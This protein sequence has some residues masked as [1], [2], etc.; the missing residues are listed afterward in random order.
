[1]TGPPEGEILIPRCATSSSPWTLAARVVV[2]PGRPGITARK[3]VNRRTLAGMSEG[4]TVTTYGKRWAD[5]Y[6]DWTAGWGW[7][8]TQTIASVCRHGPAPGP[9]SSSRSGTGRVALP[10]T[11]MGVRST[12]STSP[13]RWWPSFARSPAPAD[14]PVTMGDFAEVPVE[15]ATR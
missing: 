9:R 6:D 14:I 10:L 1:V 13:N 15:G 5:I 4:L 12:A 8:S 11:E 2:R 3:E 7:S